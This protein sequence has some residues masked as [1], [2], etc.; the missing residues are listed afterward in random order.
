MRALCELKAGHA[1]DF[2]I[3]RYAMFARFHD[4]GLL[5]NVHCL[6][7]ICLLVPGMPL[8][9]IEPLTARLDSQLRVEHQIFDGSRRSILAHFA[10]RRGDFGL[11]LQILDEAPTENLAG[12]TWYYLKALAQANLGKSEA[13]D[14]FVR[15]EAYVAGAQIP[16]TSRVFCELLRDEALEAIERNLGKLD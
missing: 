3:A 16:W 12:F 15:G 8:V 11:A 2:Q 9:E 13:R 14:S 4:D 6:L 1:N 5:R 10:I 7:Q